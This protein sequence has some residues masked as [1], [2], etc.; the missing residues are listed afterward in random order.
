MTTPKFVDRGPLNVMSCSER[1]RLYSAWHQCAVVASRADAEGY[2]ANFF[3]TLAE[4]ERRTLASKPEVAEAV[5]ANKRATAALLR[6][7][8]NDLESQP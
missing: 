1:L 3:L 7:L 4:F 5:K 2:D 8:A 6:G